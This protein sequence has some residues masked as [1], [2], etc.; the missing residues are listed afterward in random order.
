MIQINLRSPLPQYLALQSG[1]SSQNVSKSHGIIH[2]TKQEN[3]FIAQGKPKKSDIPL[4][5][6]SI[7]IFFFKL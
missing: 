2:Q 5:G 3:V 7:F 1:K 6:A 4:P